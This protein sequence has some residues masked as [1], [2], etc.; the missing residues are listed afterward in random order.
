M[1]YIATH[2]PDAECFFCAAWS[3]NEDDQHWLV[4]RG[5]NAFVI[6]NRYPYTCGHLMIAPV[7]HTAAFDSLPANI[8]AEMLTLAQSGVR[9]LRAAYGASAFN[10]GFNLGEAAGA[11]VASHLHLHVVPRWLGD[12]NFMTT[13]GEVRVLPESIDDTLTKIRAAWN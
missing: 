9:A 3:A 5:E 6:L 10:I 4:H 11:G 1:K 12:T 7:Q 13:T 8:L 2:N